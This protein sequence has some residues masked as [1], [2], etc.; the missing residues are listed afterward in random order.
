MCVCV[1]KRKTTIDDLL[2]VIIIRL[3]DINSFYGN[4]N[5]A[6]ASDP[7]ISLYIY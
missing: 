7:E 5:V 6:G 4:V 1:F 2:R 3:D